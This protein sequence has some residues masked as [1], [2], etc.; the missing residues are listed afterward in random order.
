MKME[1]G[2]GGLFLDKMIMIVKLYQTLPIHIKLLTP[3]FSIVA[4]AA[5]LGK[6]AGRFCVGSFSTSCD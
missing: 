4:P 1:G 5:G 3:I 2:G 6:I